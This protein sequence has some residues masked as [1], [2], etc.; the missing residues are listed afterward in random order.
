M[1]TISYV[2]QC[3][4]TLWTSVN[5]LATTVPVSITL[6]NTTHMQI[7]DLPSETNRLTCNGKEK[8]AITHPLY[9]PVTC[10]RIS[11]VS[12]LSKA[13]IKELQSQKKYFVRRL[14]EDQ[15]EVNSTEED[16]CSVKEFKLD[17]TRKQYLSYVYKPGDK[18]TGAKINNGSVCIL[19]NKNI[20]QNSYNEYLNVINSTD[21]GNGTSENPELEEEEEEEEK[22]SDGI[23]SIGVGVAG[24]LALLGVGL[25]I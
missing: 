17:Y 19:T 12:D 20:F 4:E 22:S 23:S 7:K 15:T 2:V 25:M 10:D 6:Y 8:I 13:E 14:S 24:V 3:V 1:T 16:D 5:Q 21:P 18:S 9:F 11:V